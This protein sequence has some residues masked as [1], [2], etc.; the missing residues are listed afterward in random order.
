VLYKLAAIGLLN[1]SL[2]SGDEARLIFEHPGNG[3]PYE[4]FGILAVG[5]SHLLEPRFNVG[6]EMYFHALKVRENRERGNTE[7]RR[8]RPKNEN[9]ITDLQTISP[10][11]SK[12]E[13]AKTASSTG[14]DH[15]NLNSQK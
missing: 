14:P 1:S 2:N 13:T 5:N 4:L 12:I 9:L 3:V 8:M 10:F 7:N 6:R 15:K 11:R